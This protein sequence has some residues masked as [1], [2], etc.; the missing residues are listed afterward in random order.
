MMAAV[1]YVENNPVTAKMVAHA[2]DWAWS[3]AKNH[4]QGRRTRLD[5]LTDMD[6]LRGAVR[7]WRAMLKHGLDAGGV[8]EIGETA[9]ET[10]E[11]RLRTG[12]PL[13]T[14]EWIAAQEKAIGRSLKPAKRG[15][16]PKLAVI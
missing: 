5:P 12:R 14:E 15:P 10:I 9:A 11:S 1:R 2:E 16:K 7:N 6:A 3:S 13:A 8:D 4:A